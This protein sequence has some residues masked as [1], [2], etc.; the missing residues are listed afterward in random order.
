MSCFFRIGQ[1]AGRLV[2]RSR[3][4]ATRFWQCLGG[5][6]SSN[7]LKSKRL[8]SLTWR[9]AVRHWRFPAHFET[10]STHESITR[11]YL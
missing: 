7:N 3:N 2:T 6:D 9:P 11:I 8:V 5:Y 4:S 10:V 1:D